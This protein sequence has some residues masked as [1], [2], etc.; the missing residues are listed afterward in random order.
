M[1]PWFSP[2]RMRFILSSYRYLSRIISFQFVP[3]LNP[4]ISCSWQARGRRPQ[5][6]PSYC[7]ISAYRPIV[8]QGIDV[9]FAILPETL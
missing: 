3:L 7:M 4:W 2:G 5:I 1:I 6:T 9:T 8:N